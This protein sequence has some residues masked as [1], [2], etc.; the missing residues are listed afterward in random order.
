M[1]DR[2]EHTQKSPS[3]RLNQKLK[4]WKKHHIKIYI[5]EKQKNKIP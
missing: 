2:H 5:T 3:I 4:G 1:K